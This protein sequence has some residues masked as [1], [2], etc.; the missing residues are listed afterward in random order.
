MSRLADAWFG[1]GKYDDLTR[2]MEEFI[3]SGGVYGTTENSLAV[4]QQK[5]KG[6]IGYILHRIWLPYELL[7]T[8][9]PHLYKRRYLQLFYEAKRWL[10]IFNPEVRKRKNRDLRAIKHLSAEKK[11]N[12][13]RMLSE[14]GLM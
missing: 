7:C 3:M 11:D 13:N 8:I 1:N 12:V 10:R 4:S 6:R 14:L 9:Y 2:H 5:E